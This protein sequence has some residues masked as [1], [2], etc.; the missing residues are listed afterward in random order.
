MGCGGKEGAPSLPEG[1]PPQLQRGVRTSF[2]GGASREGTDTGVR[3]HR[4]HTGQERGQALRSAGAVSPRPEMQSRRQAGSRWRCSC[5]GAGMGP[6]RHSQRTQRRQPRA[7]TAAESGAGRLTHWHAAHR[8]KNSGKHSSRSRGTPLHRTH[9]S[10]SQNRGRRPPPAPRTSAKALH[11][12]EDAPAAPVTRS[13]YILSSEPWGAPE[14]RLT[15]A[16]RTQETNRLRKQST[17][18]RIPADRCTCHRV[19]R[20]PARC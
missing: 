16:H 6:T 10:Q 5:C 1:P 18:Q 17:A 15:P 4:P 9:Q 14:R 13:I 11:V 20:Q 7:E 12:P 19:T 2:Q 3:P 8:S